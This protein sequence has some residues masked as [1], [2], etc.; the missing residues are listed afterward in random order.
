MRF[1][2]QPIT[3]ARRGQ[4]YSYQPAVANADGDALS[5]SLLEGPQRLRVDTQTGMLSWIPSAGSNAIVA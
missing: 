3:R 5:F 4:L 1:E 2:T